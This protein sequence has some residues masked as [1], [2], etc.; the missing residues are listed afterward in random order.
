VAT[1]CWAARTCSCAASTRSGRRALDASEAAVRTW[2]TRAPAGGDLG[3]AGMLKEL[4]DLAV[5]TRNLVSPQTLANPTSSVN[6]ARNITLGLA[7]DFGS[8][9]MNPKVGKYEIYDLPP[10]DFV[11]AAQDHDRRAVLT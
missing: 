6:A 5:A 9:A 3:L 4:P 1:A 8:L 2:T 11:R 10:H 7:T